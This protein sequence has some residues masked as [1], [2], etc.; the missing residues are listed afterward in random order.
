MER[1]ELKQQPLKQVPG[2]DKAPA[3]EAQVEA[4]R[5]NRG[6]NP[7]ESADRGSVSEK[8]NSDASRYK[9]GPGPV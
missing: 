6:Y 4:G 8:L 7:V 3:D 5:Q 9:Q 1:Q 2:Q